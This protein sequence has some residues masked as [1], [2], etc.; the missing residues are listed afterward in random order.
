MPPFFFMSTPPRS[1]RARRPVDPERRME[2]VEHLRELRDRLIRTV[3]GIALTTGLSFLFVDR[4][5]GLF[6]AVVP[7]SD[8]IHVTVFAPTEAF[9]AYFK[10]ALTFGIVFAMPLIVY[11]VFRFM[12]PGLTGAERRW[13]LL[14]VPL[15]TLFFLAGVV[16][17][18]TLVLPSALNFLLNFGSAE[19]QRNPPLNDLLGFET[20][21]LLAV[22]ITFEL[23]PVMFMLAK[24]GIVSAPRM[25]RV[26]RY[27]IVLAF[28]I[29]AIITPTPDPV[30]Q[31][32]VA[33]PVYL[34]YELGLLF[35]RLA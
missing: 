15:I 17:C 2:L 11:Q 28:I 23:P 29:A 30:N 18:Y 8:N 7:K 4:L 3:L 6:L 16:F 5:I 33:L 12:A 34:L 10:V 26:R 20:N 27:V 1:R 9:T 13:V 31:T 24:L 32:I 14:S 25:R 22:G 35:A 21:F 19:F